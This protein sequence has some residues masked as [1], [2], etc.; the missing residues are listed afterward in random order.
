MLSDLKAFIE[1]DALIALIKKGG[2]KYNTVLLITSDEEIES[3]SSK[4]IM[5]EQGILNNKWIDTEIMEK[6]L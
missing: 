4:D 6:I 1:M 2:P 5:H 3:G